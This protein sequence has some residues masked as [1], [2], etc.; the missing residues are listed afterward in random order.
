MSAVRAFE[1]A[2]RHQSFT[3][4]AEELGMTQAAISYQIRI[5][6][7]R[8]GAPLFVRLSRHVELTA[9]GERLAPGVIEAFD[10]LRATFATTAKVVDN[11]ISLSVLPTIASHW[12]VPRLGR[13][14]MA[15]RQYAV[16]LD[17]SNDLIDFDR[18][19][20]DIGIRSGQGEWPGLEARLLIPSHFTPLCSP[21]LLQGRRISKPAD[22]LSL[23]LLSP[24]D[25]WWERWFKEA[26]VGGVDLSDRPDNSLGTQHF[27]AVAATAGQGVAL[28]NPF[29]FAADLAAGRL[30]QLFDLVLKAERDYWVVCP[31][32]RSRAPKVRAFLDWILEEASRDVSQ[33]AA[34]DECRRGYRPFNTVAN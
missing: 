14:Q 5:L 20:F 9:L 28:L 34:N 23:P 26:G 21:A 31:R 27:E 3:R 18:G 17:A 4:A 33:A 12:L 19:G 11:V 10:R 13:F 22:L 16:Q 8:M 29:F 30:I 24:H 15:H 25:P 1:A 2:A 6:E 32:S 7:E